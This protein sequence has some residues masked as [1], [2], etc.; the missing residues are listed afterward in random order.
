[1]VF[2]LLILT[3]LFSLISPSPERTDETDSY[4][5]LQQDEEQETSKRD[6]SNSK[7]LDLSDNF[8][9]NGIESNGMICYKKVT[10]QEYTDYTEVMT[11]NQK[12]QERCHTSYV[13]R[14]EPHQEQRCDEKFEKSCTI[15]YEDVTH[16][17]DIEVCK[18]YLCP[19]CSKDG[20][21][22]CR[23]VY[24][25]VCESNKKVHNVLDDVV[26]CKTLFEGEG[27]DRWPVQRCETEQ[28]NVTKFSPETACREMSRQLCAPTGCAEKQCHSCETQV[29]AVVAS[30]PV[31][32]CDIEPQRVCRHVTKMLP[33]L[34]PVIDCV[35]VP[36]E[37]CGVSKT[38]PVKKKRPVILNWCYDKPTGISP[39]ED[40]KKSSCGSSINKNSSYIESPFYPNPSPNGG[41]SYFIEKSHPDICQYKLTFEDVVLANPF[42]GDCL[43]DSMHI[44]GLDGVSASTVPASLCGDLT[45]HESKYISLES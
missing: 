21:Q 43:N 2:I 31:E 32:E 30:K 20:P 35:Q 15:H 42:M 44:T 23:T 5:P 8:I 40:S 41:C 6:K 22:E 28:R 13:T 38:M 17:E 36:H 3:F 12:T 25:T 11:C 19:D 1:M 18:T 9:D 27:G 39:H 14:Y 7:P 26:T 33:K 24:D 4:L 29:K 37:V 10:L 45:G 16:N 34:E